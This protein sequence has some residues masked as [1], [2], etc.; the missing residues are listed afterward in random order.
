MNYMPENHA[1]RVYRQPNPDTEQRRQLARSF[2]LGAI[3]VLA[4]STGFGT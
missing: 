3:T 2:A 1:L 4:L